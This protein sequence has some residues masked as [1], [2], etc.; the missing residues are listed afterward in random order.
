MY[1]C[2]SR[3]I[4]CATFCSRKMN[5]T[6]YNP[7]TFMGEAQSH[8]PAW[9]KTAVV[10][11][12]IVTPPPPYRRNPAAYIVAAVTNAQLFALEHDVPGLPIVYASS[13]SRVT[14]CAALTVTAGKREP[15]FKPDCTL[16]TPKHIVGH[17][18][19]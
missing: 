17:G 15:V 4:C 11:S 12:W 1:I 2:S 5:L 6:S 19:S 3:D 10:E 13:V 14:R 18:V 9:C 16:Q 7:I 8:S